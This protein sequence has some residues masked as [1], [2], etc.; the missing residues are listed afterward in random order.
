VTDNS[1]EDFI[2]IFAIFLTNNSI[3]VIGYTDLGT[4]FQ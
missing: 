1:V 2:H 3:T 4:S